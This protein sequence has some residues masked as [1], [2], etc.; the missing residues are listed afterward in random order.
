MGLQPQARL[1]SEKATVVRDLRFMI[2]AVESLPDGL[3]WRKAIRT[4]IIEAGTNRKRSIR[5]ENVI[6]LNTEKQICLI[7]IL[8][9]IHVFV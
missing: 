5:E 1:K 4:S 7:D 6:S 2:Q 8:L 9:C 3:C